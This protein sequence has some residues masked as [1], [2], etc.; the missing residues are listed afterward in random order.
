M[1]GDRFET[2]IPFRLRVTV[3]VE[4]IQ[5]KKLGCFRLP[6]PFIAWLLGRRWLN[7]KIQE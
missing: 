7:L 4:A 2:D 3:A 6:W 5:L 1:F